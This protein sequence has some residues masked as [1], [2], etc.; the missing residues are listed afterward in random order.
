MGAALGALRLPEALST[1][2]VVVTYGGWHATHKRLRFS[3]RGHEQRRRSCAR[4]V[5][6]RTVLI[7]R[8]W[9][10]GELGSD[11]SSDGWRGW[12][13][14]D[15]ARRCGHSPTLVLA[16]CPA[17]FSH[18]VSER[19]PWFSLASRGGSNGPCACCSACN[20]RSTSSQ[21]G[22]AAWRTVGRGRGSPASRISKI[23]VCTRPISICLGP[24][25]SL[26]VCARRTR[27]GREMLARW[28]GQPATRDVILARQRA[29][30]ELRERLEWREELFGLGTEVPDG[31]ET[32]TLAAWSHALGE[33]PSEWAAKAAPLVVGV[34]ALAGGLAR[35]LAWSSSFFSCLGDSS[36][37][38][39]SIET[40]GETSAWRVCTCS[41]DVLQLARMLV[42]IEGEAFAVPALRHL[43]EGLV[44]VGETPSKRLKRL[45]RL[46]ELLDSTHNTL[47]AVLAPFL[48]W[49]TQVALAVERWCFQTGPALERRAG[50]HRGN[51][52]V[53]RPGRLCL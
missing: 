50:D 46:M 2:A 41:H 14:A 52:S 20:D 28:L 30:R 16:R 25:P 29:I 6:I 15:C 39:R 51:R 10:A 3:R 19:W 12:A 53:E 32:H 36:R 8:A 33:R 47:F 24:A 26:S 31:I 4:L 38:R 13:T 11:G 1:G 35:R 5:S 18:C 44:V 22:G 23:V 48:M 42:A 21:R 37:L 7:R 34:D 43:Q 17:P 27:L 49:T 40:A 9:R 45:V